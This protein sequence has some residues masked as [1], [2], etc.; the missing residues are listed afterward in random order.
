MIRRRSS[1]AAACRKYKLPRQ[2]DFHGVAETAASGI[3]P[4]C[5][6][7]PLQDD[8]RACWPVPAKSNQLADINR[9]SSE[10]RTS[11]EAGARIPLI[12]ATWPGRQQVL[13]WKGLN[14]K[15]CPLE[16][17]SLAYNRPIPQRSS[18]LVE[19]REW[20]EPALIGETLR[21]SRLKEL[22]QDIVHCIRL[23]KLG[24]G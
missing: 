16:F 24:A 11:A 14:A 4:W 23:L 6:A 22:D 3:R 21:I 20:N 7:R 1:L 15:P 13:P 19:P 18:R 8:S 12:A 10:A 17:S 2:A 9:A 5:A